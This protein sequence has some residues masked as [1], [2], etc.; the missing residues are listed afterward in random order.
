MKILFNFFLI[1]YF[2][3]GSMLYTYIG[4]STYKQRFDDIATDHH[5]IIELAAIKRIE[6]RYIN[7]I[8]F[9]I[10]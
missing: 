8:F 7:C 1:I 2:K 3:M 9:S 4:D 10:T 5:T 6:V